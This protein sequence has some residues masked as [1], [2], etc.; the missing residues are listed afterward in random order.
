ME[1][2]WLDLRTAAQAIV[3]SSVVTIPW[4]S[5]FIS[6]TWICSTSMGPS[7]AG[8]LATSTRS[9]RCR[10]RPVRL[11]LA[12]ELDDRALIL[13]LGLA[14]D[15]SENLVDALNSSD[16]VVCGSLS[17]VAVDAVLAGR[18]TVIVADP[19]LFR[20]SP[21]EDL[22]GVTYAQDVDDVSRALAKAASGHRPQ[23]FFH[24]D[25]GLP[26]WR[27]LIEQVIAPPL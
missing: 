26:R 21:A 22:P 11:Q 25:P 3:A 10:A 18:P 16:V 20:S 23:A 6:A 8:D 15:R 24:N 7:P 4:I 9:L 19:T 17:S 5:S 13:D 2:A 12:G 27:A 14:I 1:P